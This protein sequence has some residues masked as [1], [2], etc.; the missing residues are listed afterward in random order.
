MAE[1]HLVVYCLARP[2]THLPHW[3]PSA[4][5]VGGARTLRA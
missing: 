1:H 5:D 4:A 3:L 2:Y